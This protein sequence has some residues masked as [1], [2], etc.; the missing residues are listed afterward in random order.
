MVSV[1]YGA[2]DVDEVGS[3]VVD[4]VERLEEED[5]ELDELDELEAGGCPY[6]PSPTAAGVVSCF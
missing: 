1:T 4:T 6:P 2:D 5:K 3:S